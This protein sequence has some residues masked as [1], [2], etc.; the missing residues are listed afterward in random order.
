M[1]GWRSLRGKFGGVGAIMGGCLPFLGVW[2]P[3]WECVCREG[4]LDAI[5]GDNWVFGGHYG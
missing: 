3:F 5:L 1:G 4:G 2:R